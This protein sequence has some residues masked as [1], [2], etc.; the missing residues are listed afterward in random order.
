MKFDYDLDYKSLDLHAHPELYRIGVRGQ[1]VLLVEPYKGEVLLVGMDM[2]RRFLQM[3]MTRARRYAN[4][5]GGRKYDGPVPED[6]CG[7]SGKKQRPTRL[8]CGS[9]SGI[10]SGMRPNPAACGGVRSL[11]SPAPLSH[12]PKPPERSRRDSARLP[13]SDVLSTLQNRWD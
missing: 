13:D 5:K 3:G 8:V 7:Q 6:K 2:A 11:P 12:R 10:G 4:H 9:G 1:G